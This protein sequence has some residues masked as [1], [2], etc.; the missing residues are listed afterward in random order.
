[1]YLFRSLLCVFVVFVVFVL[2]SAVVWLV[3]RPHQGR[4]RQELGTGFKPSQAPVVRWH[5]DD[6][7]QGQAGD[8][9]DEGNDEDDERASM[10]V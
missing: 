5:D 9:D 4:F 3:V 7:D 2:C 6:N 1:M 10:L 8:E